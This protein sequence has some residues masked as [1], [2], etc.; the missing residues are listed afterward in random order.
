MQDIISNTLMLH[1]ELSL[2]FIWIVSSG[3]YAFILFFFNMLYSPV[4]LKAKEV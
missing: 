1:Q 2:N 3:F 4:I